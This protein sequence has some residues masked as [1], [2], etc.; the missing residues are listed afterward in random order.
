MAEVFFRP[1]SLILFQV[2]FVGA[3]TAH[4]QARSRDVSEYGQQFE[5]LAATAIHR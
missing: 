4:F 3:G 5:P 2:L 1:D